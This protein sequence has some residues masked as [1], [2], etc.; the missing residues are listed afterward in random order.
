MRRGRFGLSLSVITPRTP[1]PLR[2]SMLGSAD[3]DVCDGEL[4]RRYDGGE[5][6]QAVELIQG[7]AASALD[8]NCRIVHLLDS[9]RWQQDS[10]M[11]GSGEHG[12]QRALANEVCF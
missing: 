2:S 4:E 9:A 3:I 6:R 5:C 12:Y 10:T 1:E 7:A 11:P 8:G